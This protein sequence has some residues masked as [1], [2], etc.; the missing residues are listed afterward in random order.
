MG[1]IFATN[2][3]SIDY[4]GQREYL[5]TRHKLNNCYDSIMTKQKEILLLEQEMKVL[6][7]KLTTCSWQPYT[8][9]KID[10]LV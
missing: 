9:S 6:K 4:Q 7:E 2:S 8:G 3:T 1:V 5:N 10:I